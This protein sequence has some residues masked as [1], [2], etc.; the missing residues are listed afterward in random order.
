[1]RLF[2]AL[3]LPEPALSAIE[4][5]SR[6]LRLT[7]AGARWVPRANLHLTLMFFG[8]T[9]PASA[10]NT[11]ERAWSLTAGEPLEYVLDRTGSFGDRV[12]WMGGT[13][14]PGVERLASAL[15]NRRFKPHVTVARVPGGPLP[16]LPPV[17]RGLAGAFRSMAL[18]QST[19][20]PGGAVYT[21]LARWE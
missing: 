4:E 12:I 18:V 19:L 20:T 16:P 3:V 11:M 13:V 2:A 17:P 15:G 9:V 14:S 6:P 7:H 1:M 21:V 5:W 10:M 8:E